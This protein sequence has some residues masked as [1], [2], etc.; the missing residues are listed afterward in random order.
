ML[1]TCYPL[2]SDKGNK[3]IKILNQIKDSA[4][5]DRL[6]LASHI[7]SVLV[8]NVN[9]THQS[10]YKIH[11]TKKSSSSFL[12]CIFPLLPAFLPLPSKAPEKFK[13]YYTLNW[14]NLIPLLSQHKL[15]LTLTVTSGRGRGGTPESLRRWESQIQLKMLSIPP[16]RTLICPPQEKSLC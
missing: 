1:P 15:M 5:M 7:R 3:N 8:S 9:F 2:K 10:I 11:R 12:F 13:V 16:D 4:L 6:L 14:I